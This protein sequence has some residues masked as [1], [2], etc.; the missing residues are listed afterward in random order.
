MSDFQEPPQNAY[1][2]PQVVEKRGMSTGAK[3][4]LILGVIFLLCVL[5]CCGGGIIVSYM[6]GKYME[7]AVT[8]DPVV[9]AQR[10]SEILDIELPESFEP[11]ASVDMSVPVTGQSLMTFVVYSGQSSEDS[12][13]LVGIGEM[14]ANMPQQDIQQQIDN[15][16]RKQGIGQPE[17]GTQWEIE[18]KEFTIG[19]EPKTFVYRT[20]KNLEHAPEVEDVE[21]D[22]D[23]V[24]V[25][26]AVQEE[27]GEPT[28]FHVTG[29]VKGKRGPVLVL[30]TADA[31]TLSEE[32]IDQIIESIK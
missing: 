21:Q 22:E 8:E 12:I 25:E 15:E 14:L 19:G 2:S 20:A 5:L 7:D 4:L 13:V 27:D 30:I 9:V 23:A 26:D 28:R 17:S 1:V 10:K 11:Q 32:E 31:E 24:Q 6:A 3:V 16:L 18:E 29:T